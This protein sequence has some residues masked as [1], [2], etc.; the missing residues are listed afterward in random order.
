MNEQQKEK[1]EVHGAVYKQMAVVVE[2]AHNV[3]ILSHQKPDGDTLGAATAFACYL[4]HIH[5]PYTLFCVDEPNCSLDFLPLRDRLITDTTSLLME[6]YD[7]IVGFDFNTLA[8][9]GVERKIQERTE[10]STLINIDHH[11]SNA[12]FGDINIVMEDAPSTTAILHS[13]FKAADVTIDA[14]M[15]TALLTGLVTDTGSFTNAATNITAFSIASELLNSGARI[16]RILQS[17]FH[18]KPMGALK[19]WGLVLARLTHDPL[20]GIAV[21]IV[22][23][24]DLE[25]CGVDSEAVEGIAN[26]LNILGDVQAILVIRDDGDGVIR[27]SFRT[28]RDFDVS[29]LARYFGGGG[30]KKAAGFALSG[31][32]QEVQG[33]WNIV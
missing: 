26:F 13:F 11:F 15:A 23:Q 31:R 25:D 8:H 9:T 18:N 29:I 1:V 24:K 17:T 7:V 28:T 20:S 30:H 10:G 2:R 12:H 32:L 21:T 27:G 33:Q 6:K 19:L 16:Q 22:M 5:M 14:H 3:L 4:E